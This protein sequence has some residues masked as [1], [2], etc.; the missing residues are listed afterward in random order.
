[1][2]I[3][4]FSGLKGMELAHRQECVFDA[5]LNNDNLD[6]GLGSFRGYHVK[7]ALY[8]ARQYA[9]DHNL[10]S[11][12]PIFD[13]LHTSEEVM[14]KATLVEIAA[15]SWYAWGVLSEHVAFYGVHLISLA[16]LRC[17]S[18]DSVIHSL[19]Y[20]RDWFA[21]SLSRESDPMYLSYLSWVNQQAVFLQNDP[22]L[23]VGDAG[24]RASGSFKF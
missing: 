11:W 3:D 7:A 9:Q 6:I 17:Y 22:P 1:M 24:S 18:D 2:H 10:K 23:G 12:H 16:A 20:M 15:V 13:L 5:F 14:S 4:D 8:L 19:P 21:T